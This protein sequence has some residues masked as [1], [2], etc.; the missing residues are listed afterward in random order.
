MEGSDMDFPGFQTCIHKDDFEFR[1]PLSRL[2]RRAPIPLQIKPNVN[3][4][5]QQGTPQTVGCSITSLTS[6]SADSSSTPVSSINSFYPSK[7]PIPL[8]SPLGSPA[9]IQEGNTAKSQC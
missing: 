5:S 9:Y 3:L 7:D 1:R 4:G 6:T 8:L 2:Q